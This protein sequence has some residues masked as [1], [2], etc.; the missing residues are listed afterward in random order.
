[1]YPC[2]AGTAPHIYVCSI[3][4]AESVA[5][6]SQR[7]QGCESTRG[8][9]YSPCAAGCWVLFSPP[10]LSEPRPPVYSMSVALGLS[11]AGQASSIVGQGIAQSVLG[12]AQ[13]I[14]EL[15]N[16]CQNCVSH[17]RAH[18]CPQNV[19][20]NKKAAVALAQRIT[21]LVAAITTEHLP[22]DNTMS[23]E[24]QAAIDNFKM[25][26]LLHNQV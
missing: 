19:R 16:V 26:V 8:C 13:I 21:E 1:M 3:A 5:S 22:S 18:K 23:P 17:T 7:S 11:V 9:V 2:G 4:G 15:A 20:F 25:Y 12:P 6:R 14:A 10:T 24:W